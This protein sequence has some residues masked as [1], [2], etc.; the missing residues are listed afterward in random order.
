MSAGIDWG[1]LSLSAVLDFLIFRGVR[2]KG[3]ESGKAEETLSSAFK[4][5]Q[6]QT[7]EITF[8]ILLEGMDKTDREKIEKLLDHWISEGKL[9]HIQGLQNA[10]MTQLAHHLDLP[11]CLF[12]KSLSDIKPIDKD[13][14]IAAEDKTRKSLKILAEIVDDGSEANIKLAEHHLERLRI[15]TQNFI[16]DFLGKFLLIC[17]N[18]LD[19]SPEALKQLEE[20]FDRLCDDD[21]PDPFEKLALARIAKLDGPSIFTK[22][23]QALHL[24]KPKPSTI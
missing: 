14:R 17:R 4:I 6:S 11:A 19:G 2:G 3:G 7:D 15:T 12:G 18:A 10:Y 24:I 5:I 23:L 22:A 13:A 9:G 1:D 20:F 8:Q 21:E 16:Q